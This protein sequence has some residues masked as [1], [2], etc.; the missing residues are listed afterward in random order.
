MSS[1]SGRL[2]G[3]KASVTVAARKAR[4]FDKENPDPKKETGAKKVCQLQFVWVLHLILT[5][6]VFLQK[7]N[8]FKS[9]RA[10]LRS[11]LPHTTQRILTETNM[12]LLTKDDK[13]RINNYIFIYICCFFPYKI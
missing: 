8:N 1:R 13:V 9:K 6:N 12:R 10:P 2:K 4:L 7:Q 5:I 11:I 3:S